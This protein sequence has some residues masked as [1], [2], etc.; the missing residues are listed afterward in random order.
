M[1]PVKRLGRDTNS[2][3]KPKSRKHRRYGMMIRVKPERF[4]EYKRYHEAVWP[5]VLERITASKISNYSIF[6]REGWLFAYF[7]YWGDDFDADMRLMANDPETLRWWD[8]MKPMQEPLPTCAP[9]EWWA[10]MDEVFHV[11]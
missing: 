10:P 8:V 4:E 9:G 5:G 1:P 3:M 2:K 11:D 7:E 6:H